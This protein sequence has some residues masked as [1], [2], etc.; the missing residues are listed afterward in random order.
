[1]I[2][3]YKLTH[4]L[5]DPLTTKSLFTFS[6]FKSTRS[7]PFKL[8]INNSPNTV[9]YKMFFSNRITQLWNSLPEDMV[10][11]DTVNSFKNK[12]DAYFK[13]YKYSTDI[14]LYCPYTY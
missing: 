9:Q 11:A 2:E 13:N 7:H 8:V 12:F 3:T 14:N 1:M 6:D 5:Y 4:N 10:C